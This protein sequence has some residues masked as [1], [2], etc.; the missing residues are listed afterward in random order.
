MQE[1][2]K[3]FKDDLKDHTIMKEAFYY[4]RDNIHEVVRSCAQ[5]ARVIIYFNDVLKEPLVVTS[6]MEENR[7]RITINTDGTVTY[8]WTKQTWSKVFLDV[9]E[10][11]KSI[12][13]TIISG[14]LTLFRKKPL[15][16]ENKKPLQIT[17]SKPTAS[18]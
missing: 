6:G 17:D 12:T 11:A 10:D 18:K 7:L 14:L 9:K 15:S 8:A 2:F 3:K 4:V 1:A 13:Q 16:I 5:N